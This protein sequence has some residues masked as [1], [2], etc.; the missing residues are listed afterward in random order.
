[1]RKSI[2]R[3]FTSQLVNNFIIRQ[4]EEQLEIYARAQ[5]V[6]LEEGDHEEAEKIEAKISKLLTSKIQ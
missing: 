2:N 5:A 3:A 6:A 4:Q 1:M